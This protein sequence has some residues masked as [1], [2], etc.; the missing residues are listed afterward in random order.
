M[1]F[2]IY[3]GTIVLL[4]LLCQAKGPL[5][6]LALNQTIDTQ[7]R[8]T[9]QI[10]HNGEWG[11]IC[12]S[13]FDENAAKVAC[14]ELGLSTKYVAPAFSWGENGI[15]HPK[16]M[17]CRGDEPSLFDCSANNRSYCPSLG[18]N[19]VEITC[20]SVCPRMKYGDNCKEDCPCKRIN[21][22]S[23]DMETGECV[24]KPGYTGFSCNCQVGSHSCN[25]TVSDCYEESSEVFCIC[26]KGFTNSEYN[27][28]DNIRLNSK[29]I[30]QVFEGDRWDGIC[31]DN[32]KRN[33]RVICHHLNKSTEFIY[34]TSKF[35][36][37]RYAEKS[38]NCTGTEEMLSEC[39]FKTDSS[40][41]YSPV[42]YCGDCPDWKYSD[43]CSKTCDCVREASTGCDFRDGTCSCRDGF[44][45]EDCSCHLSTAPCSGAYSNCKFDRCVCKEGSFNQSASCSDL[46]DVIGFCTFEK[47]SWEDTCNFITSNPRLRLNSY[48]SM[49]GVE[50]RPKTGSDDLYYLFQDT[51]DLL[52]TFLLI[53]SSSTDMIITLNEK[54]KLILFL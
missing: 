51:S 37:F 14:R 18:N 13:G 54:R 35:Q 40:C 27:C 12:D 52:L 19:R 17:R 9:L 39:P 38:V 49:F 41:P 28:T 22:E 32:L 30:V 46:S 15:A 44:K 42:V 50:W 36:N 53:D 21:T 4:Q 16:N 47:E 2:W 24:C 3:A 1:L 26:K 34:S 48:G 20:D 43:D 29:G 8:G 23:C 45:G 33:A 7:T 25:T 5:V 31:N 10:Y 11:Y 6:R